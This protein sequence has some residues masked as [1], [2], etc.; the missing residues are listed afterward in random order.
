MARR[1]VVTGLGSLSPVGLDAPSTW[2]ALLAGTSGAG[3][4]ES[5]D[6]GEI[7]C[8]IAAEIRDFDP[9]QFMER[10]LARR[11][12]RFVQFAIVAANE[13]IAD[14]GLII[15]GSVAE[16]IGVYVGSGIGG[17]HL[18]METD[19]LLRERGPRR[20]SPFFIPGMILNMASGQISI[21]HGAK[22]PN[23]SCSTA[24][25]TGCHSIGESYRMIREGYADAMIAG[26]SEATIHPVTV[27]GFS[28]MKALST[29]N[30]E[31]EKASR[32]FD[33]S[34]DGFV[35]G[36]GA[37]ILVLEERG[38]AL[39]RGAR[40][41]AELAGYGMS[42]DAFHVS[43][44]SEDG[45][46]AVRAMKM[47]LD[48]AGVS[49][50]SVDYINAHGTSTPMGDRIEM[51]AVQEVFGEH[52]PSVAFASTK[53]MT[54]HLLGAAGGLESVVTALAV[55]EGQVPPTINL[56]QPEDTHDLD[57]VPLH[58]RSIPIR[59]ALNNSFGFGGTNASLLFAH[60]PN[61]ND[62]SMENS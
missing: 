19:K 57:F 35:M 51:Q 26:G 21:M 53:S 45:G 27:A 8:R 7:T 43:S 2:K 25:A 44:P 11:I 15:S 5:F 10:K 37:G 33:K 60:H 12:D 29:R 46:G 9:T 3:M 36:E 49:A 18:L 55:H 58:S 16:R 50:D 28:A 52:A 38:Q 1:V 39:E 20:V 40:V 59:Y 47:A 6:P 48:L 54:G 34:R 13:A 14:S 24:C 62:P 42:A 4:I 61:D 31:P 22:G 23:L 56:D 17:L 30:D 41:Y 32:P